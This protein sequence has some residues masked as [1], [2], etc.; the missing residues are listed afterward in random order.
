[1]SSLREQYKFTSLAPLIVKL[2]GYVA[3]YRYVT[4]YISW[5]DYIQNTYT[6]LILSTS[7]WKNNDFTTFSTWHKASHEEKTNSSTKQGQSTF[8]ARILG[9]S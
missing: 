9:N 6:V 1:M 5:H 2:G 8:L 3:R 7:V 4:R